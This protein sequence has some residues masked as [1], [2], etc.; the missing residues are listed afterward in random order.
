VTE[1]GWQYL[2]LNLGASAAPLIAGTSGKKI[3]VVQAL[4]V[5]NGGT[6][7][8]K[9]QSSTGPVDLTGNLFFSAADAIGGL[10]LP[11]S[12]TGWFETAAGDDLNLN[13]ISGVSGL[14]GC[15]VY[16]LA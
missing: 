6:A 13:L 5:V 4:L 8:W 11:H 16:E 10:V 12:P 1:S 15:L 9:F 2:S 3:R 14:C 7:T